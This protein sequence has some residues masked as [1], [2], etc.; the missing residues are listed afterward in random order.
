MSET[1]KAVLEAANAA[2]MQG[3]YEG[4][5]AFC[6]DD[7]NWEFV[8]EQTLRGKDAVR[9]WMSASYSEGPPGLTVDHMIAEGDFVIAVGTVT[10]QGADGRSTHH[11]YCDV[12]RL[13]GGKLA[14]LRA[15][16]VKTDAVGESG[17]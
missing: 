4:F 2:V 13:R 7:T 6:T 16:V 1:N 12:W 11:T 10:T 15:F 17:S 14:E 9:Q 5:L 3:D 8:G